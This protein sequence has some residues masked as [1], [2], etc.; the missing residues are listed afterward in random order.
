MPE[1]PPKA[2]LSG[3]T[4]GAFADV[5]SLAREASELF[6]DYTASSHKRDRIRLLLIASAGVVLVG[7][8]VLCLMFVNLLAW[9][10]PNQPI[11]MWYGAIGVSVLGVGVALIA[12]AR[13][14]IKSL[15]PLRVQSAKV[16][17]DAAE[18]FEN[19]G[20]TLDAARESLRASADA[21]REAFDV[22]DQFN[23]R[24]WAVMA[25]AISLGYLGATVLRSDGK[26][27]ISTDAAGQR[28]GS[29]SGGG[30]FAHYMRKFEPEI[31]RFEQL[32]LGALFGIVRDL[33]AKSAPQSVEKEL[34]EVMNGITVKFGGTPLQDRVLHKPSAGNGASHTSHPSGER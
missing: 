3:L 9:G 7:T 27:G 23:K 29:G 20:Q 14:R 32:A 8:I 11:W 10:L 33:V 4:S 15:D 6:R 30:T 22:S 24:P 1:R 25:G 19:A 31:V 2:T 16:M 12:T 28:D 18:T 5:R 26:P 13:R 34:E 17:Q 21:V